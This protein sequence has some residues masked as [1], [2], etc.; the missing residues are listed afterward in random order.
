MSHNDGMITSLT[1]YEILAVWR[2]RLD[3][4]QDGAAKKLGISRDYYGDLER[5]AYKP[6]RELAV[7]I[8]REVGIGVESWDAETREAVAS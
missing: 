8:Q 2:R 3:L 1:P 5:G 7:A 4:T 6:G